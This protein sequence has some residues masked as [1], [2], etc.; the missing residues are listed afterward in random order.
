VA[1][2]Q[3]AIEAAARKDQ[4]AFMRFLKQAGAKALDVGVDIGTKL[5]V[6]ALEAAAGG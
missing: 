5:A 2:V 6:K 4:S 3:N 1:G